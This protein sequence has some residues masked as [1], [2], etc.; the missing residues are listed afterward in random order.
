MVAKKTSKASPGL[1]KTQ[2]GKKTAKF[3]KRGLKSI[4]SMEELLAS[5]GTSKL[6]LSKRDEVEGVVTEKTGKT[7]V[8][9]FGGKCEGLVAERAFDEAKHFIKDVEIGDKLKAHVI[10]PETSD[11]YTILTLRQTMTSTVWDK[12][13]QAQEE[14]AEISVRV[15]NAGS[16]GVTVELF[17]L[18]GFIPN[19]HLGKDVRKNLDGLPGK[20]LRVIVI[21]LDR[22]QNRIILSERAVSEADEVQKEA[23]ILKSIKKGKVYQGKVISVPDFG[24][25]VKVFPKKIKKGQPVDR[26]VGVDGLVHVSELAWE[27][28]STPSKLYSQGDKVSVKVIGKD[29]GKLALSIKQAIDD[30]WTKAEKKYK[31]DSK[32]KGKLVRISDFGYFVQLEPGV[33]GLIHM[34]K[35]PPGTKLAEGDEIEVYIEDINPKDRRMSL[36]MVLVKKPVGYK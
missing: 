19:S 33:E 3:S 23:K 21:E 20:S 12:L 35:V 14:G 22:E 15:R 7:L 11:G 29:K 24:I 25:F 36:G 2:R 6:S 13:Q 31:K 34:T 8:I 9:D 5:V 28:V 27:K 32:A 26:Q 10:V 1:A 4:S 30:P 16:A 18:N 17:A